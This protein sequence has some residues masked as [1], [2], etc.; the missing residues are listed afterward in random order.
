MTDFAQE[1]K[2][3]A[4]EARERFGIDPCGL[5]REMR[6]CLADCGEAGENYREYCKG[7]QAKF[8]NSSA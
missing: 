2:E 3:V 1:V 7:V 8:D 5:I 6:S 4:N